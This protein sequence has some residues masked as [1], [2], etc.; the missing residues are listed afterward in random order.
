MTRQGKINF[1]AARTIA[2]GFVA[3]LLAL[4]LLAPPPSLAWTVLAPY[5]ASAL[6]AL[7]FGP[8]LFVA[9][10]CGWLLL[11][12]LCAA[13]V[14]FCAILVGRIREFNRFGRFARL[15]RRVAVAFLAFAS[16]SALFFESPS[17]GRCEIHSGKISGVPVRLAVLSDLHSCFY[18]KGQRDIVEAVERE[19]P[20]VVLL[21]GDIFDDRLP[22]GNAQTL[23]K[24]L[25]AR[26]PCLYVTGNH[27][28][29]S[30][31]VDAMKSWLR[32]AGVTVLE[33]DC[34]TLVIGGSAIDFCGVDDPT[35]L[36][37]EWD[38]QLRRA[39][40]QTDP[41]HVRVLL[42]HRPECAATYGLYGYDLVLAGH[43]HGG[44]WLIP[45]A[46][47]GC[48]APDQGFFPGFAAGRYALAGGGEMVVSRG[49]A[50]ESTPLPRFFNRP[51]FLVVEL[52]R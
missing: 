4:V 47:R 3:A 52:T 49:L 29:W 39:W 26:H 50:R 13:H 1:A 48:Y 40:A 9:F 43:A 32:Q 18:G 14:A 35:Y 5:V 7:A 16:V 8:Y 42:T 34:R 37:D 11:G 22:D 33:G 12:C 20:D 51:E 24:A 6:L 23:V 38:G 30:E 25:A 17:V 28:F 2:V 27:E 10:G 44:Q 15:A 46:G 45:F 36:A 19:R 21:V 41:A 31:R